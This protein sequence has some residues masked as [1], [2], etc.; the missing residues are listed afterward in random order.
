MFDAG[1]GVTT[2]LA[3]SQLANAI[4]VDAGRI[5]FE[6][7]ES[8]Q[9]ATDSNGDGDATDNVL[10]VYR[11]ANGTM[12]NLGLAVDNFRLS[13]SA[14]AFEVRESAQGNTDLNGDLDA[15]DN[16]VHLASGF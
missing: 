7:N 12:F 8:S 15:A 9:G 4:Q 6:V 14:I 3:L 11:A 2:N 16:V 1:T 10:H 13:R 5:A